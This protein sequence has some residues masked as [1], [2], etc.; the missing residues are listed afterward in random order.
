[1]S[2]ETPIAKF[3]FRANFTSPVLEIQEGQYRRRFV[4]DES[5]FAATTKEEA[6]MMRKDPHFVEVK[7][8]QPAD[9]QS[10]DQE[11]E[12]GGTP[13]VPQKRL[14][15]KEKVAGSDSTDAPAEGDKP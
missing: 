10:A 5:P 7:E 3:R 4:A 6:A 12:A 1:M 15:G 9:Q 11:E 14:K 8:E 13:A 2:E